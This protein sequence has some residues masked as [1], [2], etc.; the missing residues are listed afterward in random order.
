MYILDDPLSAVDAVVGRRLFQTCMSGVLKN[1]IVVL[2]THHLQYAQLA[3]AVLVLDQVRMFSIYIHT[4]HT[5]IQYFY[6][7]VVHIYYTVVHVFYTVVHIHC[8][9][10]HTYLLNC[11]TY[12]LHYHTYYKH[13]S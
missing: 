6:Y 1:S 11:C 5:Y 10:V 13:H 7:T 9:T 3:D 4:C 2:V 12:L 8:C